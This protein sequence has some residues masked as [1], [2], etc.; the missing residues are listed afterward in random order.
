MLTLSACGGSANGTFPAEWPA[1]A[2]Q[3]A[4]LLFQDSFNGTTLNMRKWFWCYPTGSSMD[5]TNN[6]TGIRYREREQYRPTQLIVSQGLL[7]LVAIRQSVKPHFSWTSGMVTTGGPFTTGTPHPSFAFRYG[8][9]E[10]RAQLPAGHGFWPAFWLLPANGAWPPEIDVMEE[11]GALPHRVYMTVHFSTTSKKDDSIGGMFDGPNLTHGFHSYGIDW[12]PGTLTWY[13]DGVNR[14]QVTAAQIE[15]RGG[16]F[17]RTPMFLLSNL[18]IGGWVSPPNK[19]TPSPASM[20][21]KYVR[22]W[23]HRP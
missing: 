3:V 12:E 22:V 1:A 6:Q 20:T 4:R 16:K 18:A 17:P 8:Y 11:Q 23:N 9:A 7:H 19:R 10:I 14:F 15:A 13:L 21:I 5:C 2:P